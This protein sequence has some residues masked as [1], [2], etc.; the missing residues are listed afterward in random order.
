MIH[1]LSLPARD[2]LHVA[3]VLVELFDG[4]LTR[5]GP[6]ANSYIVWMRDE[7]G[8]AIEVLPSGTELHPD[9]GSGQAGFRNNS[10]A[11]GFTTTHAA[12]SV[13]CTEERILAIAGRE[14]WRA[15]RLSR[16]G[17]FD[18]IEF[19]IENRVLLELLTPDMAAEYL[20]ATRKS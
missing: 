12:V 14:G 19:W 10:D 16:G 3:Q 20:R 1:H 15:L 4:A 11:T 17:A 5:F 18:V 8:S 2:P 9:S 6:H 13:A 7:H